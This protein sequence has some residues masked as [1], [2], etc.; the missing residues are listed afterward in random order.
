MSRWESLLA[1]QALDTR[2]D[3]LAV[4]REG[5]PQRAQLTDVRS[6]LAEVESQIAEVDERRNELTRSQQRLEDEVASLT[7]P[8][9][10][11][12]SSPVRSQPRSCRCCRTRG[13][14]P[15]D[16]PSG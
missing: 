13:V 1:V 3:Q 4:K 12:S 7:E 11:R 8:A 14:D 9:R 5:L 15:P 2:L 6:A 10:P 16:R